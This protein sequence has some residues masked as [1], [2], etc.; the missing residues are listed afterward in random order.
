MA[1]LSRSNQQQ[2]IIFLILLYLRATSLSNVPV[3]QPLRLL[4]LR[5]WLRS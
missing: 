2:G 3:H 5:L 1:D 4:L